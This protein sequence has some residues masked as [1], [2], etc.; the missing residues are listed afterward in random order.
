[1][2]ETQR[3]ISEPGGHALHALGWILITDTPHDMVRD[4]ML[5]FLQPLASVL[6]P[7]KT[8]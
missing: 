5:I 1:M 3:L 7:Q 2:Q 4:D 6:S 8:I